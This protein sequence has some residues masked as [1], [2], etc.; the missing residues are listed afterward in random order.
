M[1]NVLRVEKLDFSALFL[2]GLVGTLEVV[3]AQEN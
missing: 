3:T 1:G 2:C